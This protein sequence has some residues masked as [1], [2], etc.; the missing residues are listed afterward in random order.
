MNKKW[1]T[2]HYAPLRPYVNRITR[3]TCRFL[4]DILPDILVIGVS[5][6]LLMQ[7]WEFCFWR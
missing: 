5:V 6:W 1:F 2:L 7:L 4:S 3:K